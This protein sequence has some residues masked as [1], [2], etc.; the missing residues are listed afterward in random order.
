MSPPD[1]EP[2]KAYIPVLVPVEAP[3][4]PETVVPLY[5][6]ELLPAV[7]PLVAPLPTVILAELPDN[8]KYL[9]AVPPA[10]PPPINE[11]VEPEPPPPPVTVTLHLVTPA[12][13]VHVS[14]EVNTT[15]LEKP[16]AAGAAQV[17]AAPDPADVKT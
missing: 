17:G 10:P 15:K 3:P 1:A 2:P 13:T 4:V 5:T 12:G 14:E 6:K 9:I 7:L 8:E 11:F 16:P